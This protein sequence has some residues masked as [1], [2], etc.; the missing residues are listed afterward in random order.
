[1]SDINDKFAESEE[2]IEEWFDWC[3][4][5]KHDKFE[6]V[7]PRDLYAFNLLNS[8]VPSN[9]NIVE[10]ASHDLI[11]LRPSLESL[12]GIITHDQ[13]KELYGCGVHVGEYGLEKYV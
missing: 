2:Q 7:G 9:N 8:L 11:Y 13:V 10:C 1:M 3:Y 4:N 12:V 5:N 6:C